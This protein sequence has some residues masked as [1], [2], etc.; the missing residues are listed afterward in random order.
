M[1][2]LSVSFALVSIDRV[3]TLSQ[4]MR[5]VC[6]AQPLHPLSCHA[7]SLSGWTCLKA[8]LSFWHLPCVDLAWSIDTLQ[9][10]R[11]GCLVSGC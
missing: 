7:M 6:I 4:K 1:A 11:S 8:D 9:H 5:F 10:R 3:D 2:A